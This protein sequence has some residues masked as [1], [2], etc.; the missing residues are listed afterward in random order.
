MLKNLITYFIM[1]RE[2]AGTTTDVPSTLSATDEE[3]EDSL[4]DG[5]ESSIPDEEPSGDIL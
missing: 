4:G 3:Q 1:S 5:S 2:T